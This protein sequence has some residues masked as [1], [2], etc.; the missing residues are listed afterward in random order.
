MRLQYYLLT[1]TRTKQLTSN[2]FN[3]ILHQ[4]CSHI[5]EN[6]KNSS[7]VIYRTKFFDFYPI[8]STMF[9]GE[10]TSFLQ[11]YYKSKKS[12]FDFLNTIFNPNINRFSKGNPSMKLLQNKELWI[13][14]E[15]LLTSN[16]IYSGSL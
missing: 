16:S 13:E 9:S 12:M 6:Y 8:G 15:C 7:N 11:N 3:T 14:G 2:A 5:I 4:N 1:E 10:T